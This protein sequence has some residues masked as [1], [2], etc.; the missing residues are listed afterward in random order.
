MPTQSSNNHSLVL[1]PHVLPDQLP[2]THSRSSVFTPIQNLLSDNHIHSSQMQ[3]FIERN[4]SCEEFKVRFYETYRTSVKIQHFRTE[5]CLL[6]QG[7]NEH[8]L[9]YF[10]R[11]KTL[12]VEIDPECNDQW[13]KD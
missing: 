9:D 6:F 4:Y 13:L 7:D 10:E 5:G 8:M 11:L 2:R 12:M 3:R 1:V